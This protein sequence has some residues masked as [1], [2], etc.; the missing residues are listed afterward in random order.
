M[1]SNSAGLQLLQGVSARV[2]D[3]LWPWSSDVAECYRLPSESNG[4]AQVA[5]LQGLEIH[6]WLNMRRKLAGEW[7]ADHSACIHEPIELGG[8]SKMRAQAH[9]HPRRFNGVHNLL[10]GPY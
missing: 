3:G 2:L 7:P 4:S 5:A 6:V 8:F 1:N 10:L 9:W